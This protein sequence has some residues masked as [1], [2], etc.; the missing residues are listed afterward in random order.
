MSQKSDSIEAKKV[1][2]P[3]F[4]VSFPAVFQPKAFEQQEPKYSTVMLFDKK[5]NLSGL[6]EAAKAAAVEKWGEDQKKWPKNMRKPFRDGDEKEDSVG[7]PGT[8]FVSASSK[9]QPGLVGPTLKP[10]LSEKDFYAGCYARAELIAFAYDK[11][12]NRGVGFALQNIQKLRDGEKFS[13][14]KDPSTVFDAVEDDSDDEDSYG[15]DGETAADG[16]GF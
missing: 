7:Y 1:V 15:D 5:T 2:T 16:M 13:G 12:G 9:H 3:E 8:I 11:A 6:K 14:R 4:R 10:I